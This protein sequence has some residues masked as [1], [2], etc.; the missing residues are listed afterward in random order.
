M[1]LTDA[2]HAALRMRPWC[3]GC[4]TPDPLD[5]LLVTRVVAGGPPLLMCSPCISAWYEGALDRSGQ[6]CRQPDPCPGCAAL[7]AQR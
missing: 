7:G 5:I 3:D 6:A 2:E 4:H 1:T